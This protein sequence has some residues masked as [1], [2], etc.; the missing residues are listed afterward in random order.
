ML[1]IWLGVVFDFASTGPSFG[2]SACIHTIR[3]DFTGPTGRRKAAQC[4]SKKLYAVSWHRERLSACPQFP[5]SPNRPP[6]KGRAGYVCR[7]NPANAYDEVNLTQ[8][9]PTENHDSADRS[10][11]MT[12]G[13]LAMLFH[14]DPETVKRRARSGHLPGFKFGKT[15]LF[16]PRDIEAMID[17]A[18]GAAH[19][20]NQ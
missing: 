6:T 1:S 3:P 2:K 18:I 5:T 10:V 9:Y 16:R 7:A 11:F 17:N 12:V 19:R 8:T 20:R 4:C 15:W 13:D 14:C